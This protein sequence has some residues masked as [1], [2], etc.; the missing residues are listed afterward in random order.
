MALEIRTLNI[1]KVCLHQTSSKKKIG[2]SLELLSDIYAHS[3][4]SCLQR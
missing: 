4:T 1:E 2:M 3:V